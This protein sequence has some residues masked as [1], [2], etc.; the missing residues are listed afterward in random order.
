MAPGISVNTPIKQPAD[1]LLIDG[2]RAVEWIR[3]IRKMIGDKP[4]LFNQ[5]AGDPSPRLS[6]SALQDPGVAV[7]DP[8]LCPP[9]AASQL[10]EPL[11]FGV[12]IRV[13]RAP[14]R[15]RAEPCQVGCSWRS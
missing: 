6:L 12:R 10:T 3:R 5:I 15:T 2:I 8:R 11:R 13:R 4:L 9:A 1:V 7:G 14:E